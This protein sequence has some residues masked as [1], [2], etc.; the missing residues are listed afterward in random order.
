MRILRLYHLAVFH[1]AGVMMAISSVHVQAAPHFVWLPPTNAT[2]G[3][4]DG[5]P[6][7]TVTA[8]FRNAGS[9]PLHLNN[10]RST[11]VCSTLTEP[12]EVLAPGAVGHVVIT[13]EQTPSVFPTMRSFG[14]LMTTDDPDA[15]AVV[16]SA[17]A[18]FVPTN[19]PPET[20]DAER[21]PAQQVFT[22]AVTN[23]TAEHRGAFHLPELEAAHARTQRM[24][25]TFTNSMEW[26][27]RVPDDVYGCAAD[28]EVELLEDDG[29]AR[30]A[31]V[32]TTGRVY[33]L[34]ESYSALHGRGRH[35]F[36]R[37]C[38]ETCALPGLRPAGLRVQVEHAR[39]HLRSLQWVTAEQP[40]DGEDERRAAQHAAKIAA[41]NARAG[42]WTAG[43]TPQSGWSYADKCR[44]FPSARRTGMLPNLQGMEYYGGGIFTLPPDAPGPAHRSPP[45]WP[46][47]MNW[48]LRHGYRLL[49]PVKDQGMTDNGWAYAFVGALECNLNLFYN[50]H[51]DVVLAEDDLLACSGALT[52]DGADLARAAQY[53]ADPGVVPAACFMRTGPERA[54]AKC[55]DWK[56]LVVRSSEAFV[57]NHI[58][59]DTLRHLLVRYGVVVAS[60]P[61]W[62]HTFAV[63]GW[64]TNA[65]HDAPVWVCRNSFGAPWGE[66]GYMRLSCAAEAF[67]PVWVLTTPYMFGR[68]QITTDCNDSDGDGFCAW[69][70]APALP[71][72]CCTCNCKSTQDFDDYDPRQG[73]HYPPNQ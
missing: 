12:P 40:A 68:Q 54:P 6:L 47:R 70:I 58:C 22:I 34:V 65:F 16:W 13:L 1:L 25:V 73:P 2:Y 9:A 61:Q 8:Q 52:P 31:L 35:R 51:L 64:E 37:H 32:D 23:A 60:L 55:S 29:L 63:V 43:P 15:P 57:T 39:V 67:D 62:N 17:T 41:L 53:C 69:G 46:P 33:L 48:Q 71:R 3:P 44:L 24:D 59:N 66:D 7:V 72:N 30:I 18:M 5:F 50:K 20:L 28:V 27:V 26:V 4:F 11:C 49:M 56:Q 14:F 45:A 21:R 19:A 38:E 42:T 36:A 10:A